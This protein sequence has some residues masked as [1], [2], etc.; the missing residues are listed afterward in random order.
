M[1]STAKSDP[2]V[3]RDGPLYAV[4][5]GHGTVVEVDP[6]ENRAKETRI[7]T[8]EDSATMPTRFPQFMLKPSN[9]VGDAA[10]WGTGIDKADPH[11]PMMDRKGRLWMTSTV[12][13]RENS[14]WCKAG[15]SNPFAAN[16]PLARSGRQV[17]FFDPKTGKFTLID[18][19]FNTHHLQFTDDDSRL[20][21]SGGSDV[22]SWVDVKKFDQTGDE[23]ASQG[24]CPT[25]LDTNGD[26]RITKPWNEPLGGGK[27][28]EEGGGGGRVG[29]LDP[30][31]DTRILF[32]S[33]G[34]IASPDGAAWAASTD[35]PG[36]LYRFSPGNAPPG[37]CMTELYTIPENGDQ[38]FGPRGIDVDRNGVIWTA[39]SGSSHLAS[40]DR[41][42]CH[43]VQR[44]E[45]GRWD[46][47]STGL[48]V[49]SDGW[50]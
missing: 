27:D 30:K 42:K 18:S 10:H 19:C 4:S 41:R 21:F 46:A 14:P 40:F 44:S 9:F 7:P 32:G 31:L 8:R 50:T 47:V 28:V 20:Y 48:V 17:S 33:Y 23:I 38:G 16:Y 24:W 35:F 22:M 37:S 49:L 45:H 5:A 25:V 39:L 13:G 11:N 43:R 34:V 1:I 29:K 15:S 12:R 3:N 26:G 2:L 6:V 36:H